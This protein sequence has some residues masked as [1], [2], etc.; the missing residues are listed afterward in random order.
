MIYVDILKKAKTSKYRE[1][2]M[3]IKKYNAL[4]IHIPR[5]GGTSLNHFFEK[6]KDVNRQPFMVADMDSFYGVLKINENI[7]ELDHLF[8]VH[9]K[10]FIQAE[11]LRNLK[12]YC[13]VRD[14]VKRM[15][16]VYRRAKAEQDFRGL[17]Q[18]GLAGE[19][20]SF[21]DFV[22]RLE[23]L[24]TKNLFELSVV[25]QVPHYQFTHFFPQCHYI[26]DELGKQLVDHIYPIE[27]IETLVGDIIG[28]Q[29]G[30]D[31]RLSRENKSDDGIVVED[32]EIMEQSERLKKIY[33]LDYEKLA[34][35]F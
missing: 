9:F 17:T 22:Q 24:K 11:Q 8:R 20:N 13:V 3:L 10:N 33:Q 34:E 14:P 15:V 12:S 23:I 7:Y 26:F 27:K 18:L 35:F 19:I 6:R 28:E 31:K 1:S 16:S 4:L 30:P 29:G 25:N 21:T 32:S 2:L 5:N